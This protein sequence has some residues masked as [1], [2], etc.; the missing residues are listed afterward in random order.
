MRTGWP[1]GTRA[2]GEGVRAGG[3]GAGAGRGARDRVAFGRRE[4]HRRRSRRSSTIGASL[5]CRR[6]FEHGDPPFLSG[7]PGSTVPQRLGAGVPRGRRPGYC[8]ASHDERRLRRWGACRAG[9]TAVVTG[10]SRGLG[11]AD[12]QPGVRPGRGRRRSSSASRKLRLVGEA[13]RPGD[14]RPHRASRVVP[15]ACHGSVT[16]RTS[17]ALLESKAVPGSWATWTCSSTTAGM[18][19]LAQADLGGAGLPRSCSDKVIF[20]VNFKAP[21]RAECP[22]RASG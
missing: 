7:R 18:S 4:G 1:D 21:F 6:C 13:G 5:R 15:V 8:S 11:L 17:T 22:V 14:H 16:G 20:S 10:G 12:G 3:R 19:P 9:R 2:A